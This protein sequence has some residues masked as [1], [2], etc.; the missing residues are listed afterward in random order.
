M[1]ER[2][3]G[4]V[5]ILAIVGG[6]ALG[7]QAGLS[8]TPMPDTPA[9][10]ATRSPSPAYPAPEPT[11][12]PPSGTPGAVVPAEAERAVALAREDLARRLG[13]KAE[14][15]AVASVEAVDWSSTALGCPEPGKTYATVI[16]PGYRVTLAAEGQRYEYHT[17]TGTQAVLCQGGNRVGAMPT[18]TVPV[19]APRASRAVELARADL[20]RRLNVDPATIAVV[21]VYTDEFPIQN[22]GCWPPGTREPEPVIPAFVTGQEIRLAVG[23][24]EYAY[25]AHGGAVVYC[26]P[27]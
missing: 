24:Q 12:P 20:A 25:R 26:G 27:R 2:I 16:T 8:N 10:H 13:L 3:G 4:I 23:E 5:L 17:D 9:S 1:S 22:L 11:L 14:A 6:L 18:P 15:I 19:T 7:C 21:V